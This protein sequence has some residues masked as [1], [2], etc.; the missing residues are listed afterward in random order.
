MD[1]KNRR[2][3]SP[4]TGESFKV[5]S[6]YPLLDGNRA[7]DVCEGMLDEGRIHKCDSES[8]RHHAYARSHTTGFIYYIRE[9]RKVKLHFQDTDGK[10]F[11]MDIQGTKEKEEIQ[12]L[13]RAQWA[14]PPWIKVHV[15]RQDDKPFFLENG[16]K[17]DVWTEYVPKDDPRPEVQLRI[18]LSDKTFLVDK[19]RID[20]DPEILLK[21]LTDKYGF[22]SVKTRQVRFIP[23]TPWATGQTVSVIF[24]TSIACSPGGANVPQARP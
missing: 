24:K 1:D 18:D 3:A 13:F 19:V 20:N 10:K 5:G 14:S 16:A 7:T 17:Y 4:D 2:I 23:E 15:K 6:S 11:S 9:T 8:A 21:M 22:P 12:D